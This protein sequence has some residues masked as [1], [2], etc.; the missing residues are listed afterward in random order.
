MKLAT[1]F[2]AAATLLTTTLGAP[3][4]IAARDTQLTW[5]ITDFTISNNTDN[6]SSK[7]NFNI[8]DNTGSS[9]ACYIANAYPTGTSLDA[10]CAAPGDNGPTG[11]S[12]NPY[13]INWYY[14]SYNDQAIME[15]FTYTQ[16]AVF[17]YP[18]ASNALQGITEDDV[19]PNTA[20]TLPV[21]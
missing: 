13:S 14:D 6:L 3:T 17:L 5:T 18:R 19:G 1:S 21:G 15:V 11:N 16:A 20:R 10:R 9:T 4:K 8:V 7:Y 12:T 2:M